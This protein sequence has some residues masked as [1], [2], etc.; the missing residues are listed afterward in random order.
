M[1]PWAC[2]TC[3]C[4]WLFPTFLPTHMLY[5]YYREVSF[6]NNAH[7]MLLDNQIKKNCELIYGLII[8][9]FTISYNKKAQKRMDPHRVLHFLHMDCPPIQCQNINI[10][11]QSLNPFY[12]INAY[13]LLHVY[14]IFSFSKYTCH[15]NTCI[16][17][18]YIIFL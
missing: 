3:C 12:K 8:V 7:F 17:I 16:N 10:L 14:Y 15:T 13:V 11:K 4:F 9:F 18:T 1:S 6:L 2:D 5:Y